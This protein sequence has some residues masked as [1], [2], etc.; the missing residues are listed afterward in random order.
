MSTLGQTDIKDISKEQLVAGFAQAGNKIAANNIP[1]SILTA[2]QT[3]DVMIPEAKMPQVD[4]GAALMGAEQVTGTLQQQDMQR[5]ERDVQQT[6]QTFSES[7][8]KLREGHG[9]LATESTERTKM[10]ES[11]GLNEARKQLNQLS[12]QLFNQTNALRQFDVN[13]T[14]TIESERLAMGQRGGT[15]AQ[16]GNFNA[17]AN[18]QMAVQ[19]ANMVGQLYATQGSVQLMQGN[20]QMA[21]DSIEKALNSF[22]E[23]KRQEM[24]M[25]MMFYQRNAQL[26][27]K[28]QDRLAQ[29]RM[30]EI[31]R[32]QYEMDRAEDA[33]TRVTEMGYATA[34]E[35]EEM[36][37]AK[38]P[39]EQTQK[40]REVYAR[41][42]MMERQ[43]D[44]QLRK[45]QLAKIYQDMAPKQE[46]D[47][48][49]R[50]LSVNELK[51]LNSMGYKLPMGSTVG[52]AMNAGVI[53]G[54]GTGEPS[55]FARMVIDNPSLLKD[56][57]P[58]EKGN[59]YK[60]IASAGGQVQTAA[61]QSAL[62]MQKEALKSVEDIL[63]KPM[64]LKSGTGLRGIT[65][66]LPGSGGRQFNVKLDTLK[67]QLELPNLE[68]LAGLGRMSQEQFKTLQRASSNLE[69][70]EL[71]NPEM[72]RQLKIIE[73]TLKESIASG[74][75]SGSTSLP[76][77]SGSGS[78]QEYLKLIG[79]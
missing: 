59:I 46:K 39:F 11:S 38:T 32:E 70:R 21:A 5:K 63:S 53:P 67:A 41:G 75:K 3:P 60:E 2:P 25:E 73:D 76:S 19:R 61:Q 40:A 78:Y 48:S 12:N 7:E 77:Q 16:F 20:V 72:K 44:M 47:E 4:A 13:F 26:F 55:D 37:K 15:K 35:V 52:D 31:Q 18:L 42:A 50:V 64:Q 69:S 45:A 65:Y 9:I 71:S 34:D 22:Y 36:M 43:L 24:Q 54:Q 58:T 30:Q 68:F 23:P 10:E 6:G 56:L 14:N 8:R 57:T 51:E 74:E 49:A 29:A 79:Q 62:K 66:Y 33:V 28:A 27:D 17:E 1:A